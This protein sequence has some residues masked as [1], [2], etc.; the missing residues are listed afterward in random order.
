MAR[1]KRDGPSKTFTSLYIEAEVRSEKNDCTVMAITILTGLPYFTVHCAFTAAGRKRGKG[2]SF[3]VQK[4]A[5]EAL[6]FRLVKMPTG[7]RIAIIKEYP[8]AHKGLSCITT[9][10]P[11]RFPKVWANKPPMMFHVAGHVAAF[12]DGTVHDWTVNSAKR[13]I[14][15]YTVEKI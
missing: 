4:L 12:K 3:W 1:I 6:G 5:C 11:R 8:G 10:H 7:E 13:V 2:A 9:H 15:I 14:D